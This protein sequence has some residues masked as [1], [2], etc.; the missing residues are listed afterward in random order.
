MDKPRSNIELFQEWLASNAPTLGCSA[1]LSDL[2]VAESYC[3]K[4][5]LLKAPILDTTD[6]GVIRRVLAAVESDKIF[7]VTYKNRKNS[8]HKAPA[9][10]YKYVKYLNTQHYDNSPEL[11]VGHDTDSIMNSEQC[12]DQINYVATDS[13]LETVE[14][15][16]ADSS[17]GV[18]RIL[19]VHYKYGFRFTSIRELLRFRQFAGEMNIQIP[20]N[21]EE[22]KATIISSGTI[23]EDKVYCK[24]DDMIDELR[25]LV[26]RAFETGAEVVYYESLFLSEA[27]WMASHEITSEELLKEYL[28]KSVEGCSFSKKFLIRGKKLTEKE[29]VTSEIKRVWGERQTESVDAL[30][31]RLPFIPLSNILRVISGNDLFVL[32]STGVYLFLDRFRI[33]ADEELNIL[34][35][36][37]SSCEKNGFASISDIPLGDIEEE[38]FELSTLAIYNAICKKILSHKYHLNGRILTMDKPELDAITL[39]KQFIAGRTTCSFDEVADKVVELTGGSNRQYAFQAL[40]DNMVRTG[41]NSFVADGNVTFNVDEIDKIISGFVTDHFLAI[42]DITTFAMFPITGQSWSHY[43]LESYCYR[44][45]RKYTLHVLNFNNK[46]AGIIAEKDYNQQYAEMLAIALAR[47]DVELSPEVAGNFLFN[48]GYMA[49][50]KYARLDEIVGQAIEIRGTR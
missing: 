38:N 8:I 3:M 40:Y 17:I 15:Q 36:V 2:A 46:N 7:R 25:C 13:P 20:E 29:A 19:N 48:A 12:N 28:I 18:V 21:D 4:K 11:Q 37:S 1:V 41:P 47:E 14:N 39:L 26:S 9:L 50:S 27:D 49:K 42:R 5:L 10:Y 30:S 33:T 32:S 6:V 23:I 31:K 45:S 24:N 44:F 22:L 16:G 43:L 34:S 35:F